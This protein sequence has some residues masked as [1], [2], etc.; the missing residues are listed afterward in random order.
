VTV[1]ALRAGARYRCFGDGLC[2]SDVHAFGPL[3]DDE[4]ALL[5]GLAEGVVE[6]HRGVRVLASR[7]DGTCIFR[8]GEGCSIHARLGPSVKPAT[9]H[10]FPL[11][12]IATAAGPRVSTAHRCP[13][14]TMG[15][16]PPLDR[17]TVDEAFG[18]APTADRAAPATIR[19]AGGTWPFA[20]YAAEVEPTRLEALLDP[21]R[22]VAGAAVAPRYLAD[23]RGLADEASM[24]RYGHGLRA[25]AVGLEAV[26]AGEPAAV[27]WP[28][29]AEAFDRAEARS[30]D[31]GAPEA[32]LRDYLADVLWGLEWAADTTLEALEATLRLAAEVARTLAAAHPSPRPDRAMAE[33]IAVVELAT[34]SDEWRELRR[35]LA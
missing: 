18:P 11:E 3:S 8:E 4:A 13:C 17:A 28:P 21:G 5:G 15:A 26:L 16:R 29:W 34:L 10:Q 32:M 33:A 1:V 12:W 25:F 35:I 27:R 20:V 7:V 6:P 19:H 31:E 14:R 2:C 22:P 23:V 9:C 24:T 30:P